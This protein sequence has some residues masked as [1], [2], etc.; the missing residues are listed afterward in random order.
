MH[1]I[2]TTQ[3]T[4]GREA[5]RD[6]PALWHL[7]TIGVL[8]ALIEAGR[9]DNTYR[10]ER[11][12]RVAIIDTS[13]A[14]GHPCLR[15]A[16]NRKLAIDFFSNRLGAFP[17][18]ESSIRIDDIMSN[19]RTA[20]ANDLPECGVLLNEILDRLSPN[21]LPLINGVEATASP[22]FST[23]GTAIAGLVAGRPTI[24]EIAEEYLGHGAR[25]VEFPLPY[26]G[27]DPFCEVVPISTNFDTDPE[28]LIF[29]FL[30]AELID[31]DVILLPRSIPDPYRTLPQIEN[32]D[33]KGHS[34]V[35]LVS[36]CEIS[37][38][39]KLL[40]SELAQLII[41]ISLN[42]PIICAAGNNRE[43]QPIYPANLA[44]EHNGIISVG[45]ANA[46][47]MMSSY[48]KGTNATVFAPSN[49]GE[50]YDRDEIRLD[51]QNA[52]YDPT[53]LPPLNDNRKFSHFEIITTDVPGIHGYSY[54]PFASNE[55]KTGM[56]EFGSYFCRF[57][58]TSAASAL[59]AGFVSLGFSLGKL[60]KRS[61][62]VTA[63]SWLLSNTVKI[64]TDEGSFLLPSWNGKVHFPDLYGL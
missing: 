63:K 5:Y 60:Q 62:G 30:Y 37:P 14:V 59:V 1:K 43:E 61:D 12:T 33:V 21:S 57:G 42:R 40:W 4:L 55:P 16:V 2:E 8:P 48:S 32:V 18:Y 3:S 9:Q 24:V 19:A 51:T 22:V 46:K 10:D 44:T 52:H 36:V 53:G 6:Y 41:N 26:S 28:Q 50:A 56:R 38:R 23:H 7:D 34:L 54:S 11:K 29:A 25:D 17:Y 31:A 20:A 58:G 47:G 15:G 13:V 27:V 35:D 39:E 49:D 64:L 45:A